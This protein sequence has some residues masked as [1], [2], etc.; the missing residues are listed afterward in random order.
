MR[1]IQR[2]LAAWLLGTACLG[3]ALFGVVAYR[4]ILVE[5]NEAFDLNLAQVAQTVADTLPAAPAI[6][7]A[8]T[9]RDAVRGPRPDAPIVVLRWTPDGRLLSASDA[10]VRLAFRAAP[11][12]TRQRA[13]GVDW[14]VATVVRPD[15]V[16]QAAQD[17]AAQE[18]EAAEGAER[19]LLPFGVLA[20]VFGALLVLALRRG[21]QPLDATTRLLAQRSA[22]LLAPIDARSMPRELHP[23]VGALN[24]LMAR[25][26]AAFDAQRRFVADAAHELRTPITALRLQAELV[27]EARDDGER[28]QAL[29]ELK[30]GVAR[31]QHLVA[32][33]LDLSRTEPGG[34]PQRVEPLPLDGLARDAVARHAVRAERSGVDLG[35]QADVPVR[36]HGDRDELAIL[37]DNLIE[38]ALRYAGRGST[39]DV[40][41]ACID[42]C[43]AL[44]VVDDGPGVPE[45][46]R[47]A[48]FERFRRGDPPNGEPAHEGSGLGL[49]IVRAI[50]ERHGAQVALRTPP[51][52]RGL[53]ARVVFRALPADG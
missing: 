26:E 28:A 44:Q 7:T 17:A 50:A 1:S 5:M 39:V 42:G 34:R 20:V 14:D 45:A 29:A 6:A 53:E 11:G 41:A 40:V 18:R 48:L 27:E 33:L 21:L 30:A 47:E 24:D 15:V 4:L 13:G 12:L 49:S 31:A 37:V 10:G 2:R 9:P 52:G 32:Q 8:G 35:A 19:L 25:L 51:S 38:N 23:L 46:A 22:A 3:T 16:V 36:V 43:P